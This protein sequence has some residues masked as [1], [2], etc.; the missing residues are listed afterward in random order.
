MMIRSQPSPLPR[1]KSDPPFD[2][3]TLDNGREIYFMPQMD[4]LAHHL[5]AQ[6][7]QSLRVHFEAEDQFIEYTVTPDPKAPIHASVNGKDFEMVSGPGQGG[8]E[9]TLT[10]TGEAGNFN[11]DLYNIKDGTEVSGLAGPNNMP[12]QQSLWKVAQPGVGDP[13]LE[14]SGSFACAKMSTDFF[15]EGDNLHLLGR[16]GVHNIDAILSPAEN[17]WVL[18][19]EFGDIE[20]KQTFTKLQNPNTLFSGTNR[21]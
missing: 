1:T 21:S 17:G 16:M 14:G 2:L 6:A 15:P 5:A 13:V 19:G 20:F 9:A 7:Q 11:G 10:G 18:Q 4:R 12:V 8:S 3:S